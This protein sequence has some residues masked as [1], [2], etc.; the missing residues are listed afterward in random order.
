MRR[1]IICL[2]VLAIYGLGAPSAY[3]APEDM[4]W[5][6]LQNLKNKDGVAIGDKNV[7]GYFLGSGAKR[8]FVECN[9]LTGQP[10]GK[11]YTGTE[12][13]ETWT[14][15]VIVD[16]D[17]VKKEDWSKVKRVNPVQIS[18]MAPN[19]ITNTG[20][21]WEHYEGTGEL[22]RLASGPVQWP[23]SSGAYLVP[24]SDPD[25][26]LIVA[27]VTNP[28]PWPVKASIRTDIDHWYSSWYNKT[29]I[30]E[31]IEAGLGA[32]ETRFVL[33]N[34]GKKAPLIMRDINSHSSSG[35]VSTINAWSEAYFNTTVTE[36][37]DP[38][39]PEYLRPNKGFIAFDNYIGGPSVPKD[40][41]GGFHVTHFVECTRKHYW[42]AGLNWYFRG[43]VTWTENGWKASPYETGTVN[44]N[45]AKQ[46]V[47]EFF[48]AR[49]IEE[50][51]YITSDTSY[52]N[53][54]YGD[55][56]FDRLIP[57]HNSAN[58][59]PG[60]FRNNWD[61][62]GPALVSYDTPNDP[63][64]NG[65]AR[66]RIL[67]IKEPVTVGWSSE[68]PVLVR[69]PMFIEFHRFRPSESANVGR[70]EKEI[71]PG[72]NVYASTVERPYFR[73][74]SIY[75]GYTVDRN[76]DYDWKI[77]INHNVKI[78]AHNP[79]GKVEYRFSD[80]SLALPNVYN[81]ATSFKEALESRIQAR[82]DMTKPDHSSRHYNPA[83]ASID[84]ITV[85]PGQVKTISNTDT[86]T[87]FIISRSATSWDCDSFWDGIPDW[88]FVGISQNTIQS[89]ANSVLPNYFNWNGEAM[90]VGHSTQLQLI[91]LNSDVFT[92]AQMM[93]QY[94]ERRGHMVHVPMGLASGT[95][96][97]GSRWFTPMS[98]FNP[99]G[100][101]GGMNLRATDE[102]WVDLWSKRTL[103]TT[104]NPDIWTTYNSKVRTEFWPRIY[105]SSNWIVNLQY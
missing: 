77:S 54:V 83:F 45:L 81:G 33:I 69:R 59:Y 87:E 35:Y 96:W 21:D 23:G 57:T 36:N 66:S 37:L 73:V 75:K 16:Y 11:A 49:T 7:Y 30:R 88:C 44:P 46:K 86:V 74:E 2:I 18:V 84:S 92:F 25:Y 101:T 70:L 43:S 8:V 10:V 22:R 90:F 24:G 29:G 32:N 47:E 68:L 52:N 56:Y 1:L 93:G 89:V 78:T 104:I 28:N 102:V 64:M 3:A 67:P 97:R 4:R 61:V 14:E 41:S 103:Q 13:I 19:I 80:V 65:D 9:P 95:G 5:L 62:P 99:W 53:R 91:P 38:E 85:G 34:R 50:I 82:V 39:L 27:K 51:P 26:W 94:R 12:K 20:Y 31:V 48:A 60:P 6:T 76:G 100:S 71:V 42:D 63:D 105:Y 15:D 79:D 98:Y 17:H 40:L 58:L 72:Y 55:I